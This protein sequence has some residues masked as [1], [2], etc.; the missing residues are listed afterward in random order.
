MCV[1]LVGLPDVAVVG[2]VEE[3]DRPL[4]VHVE[5][6]AGVAGSAGYGTLATPETLPGSYPQPADEAEEFIDE[7]TADLADQSM[8]VEARSL[9]RTQRR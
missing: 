7:L 6:N 2:V 5:T 8:P 3:A 4:Q 1:L 9:G